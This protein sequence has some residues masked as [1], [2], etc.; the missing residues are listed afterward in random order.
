[1]CPQPQKLDNDFIYL[2]A[3]RL[4]V[5]SSPTRFQPKRKLKD[6]ET[7]SQKQKRK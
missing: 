3:E 7:A 1:M 4:K 2:C 5:K 6:G